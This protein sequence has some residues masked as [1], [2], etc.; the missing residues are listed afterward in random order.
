VRRTTIAT[1]NGD[2]W[3][4]DA[5]AAPFGFS[6]WPWTAADLENTS[7]PYLL[8]NRDFLTMTIDSA[9]M[10]VGGVQGWGARQLDPYLLSSNKTYQM[11]FM[12]SPK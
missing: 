7:H 4:V 11:S 2:G 6:L 8:K 9:Q 12:L 1:P 5:I 3:I 10:G